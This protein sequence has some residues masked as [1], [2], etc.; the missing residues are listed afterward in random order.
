MT[1]TYEHRVLQKANQ[2]IQRQ[3]DEVDLKNKEITES[4]IYALI[5]SL[6]EK[7]I[8]IRDQVENKFYKKEWMIS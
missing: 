5:S 2:L 8:Y 1:N 7:K 6:I 4:I 3:K